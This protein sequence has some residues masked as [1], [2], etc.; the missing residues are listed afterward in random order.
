MSRRPFV[1][2]LPFLL[3]LAAFTASAGS[4]HRF[5]GNAAGAITSTVPSPDGVQLTTITAGHATQLG[6][7]TRSESLLLNPETGEFT[8]QAVFVARNGDQLRA[9]VVGKFVLPTTAAG[10]YTFDGGTGRYRDANGIAGFVVVSEDGVNFD[11]LFRGK[12]VR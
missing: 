10:S 1:F 12:V 8:G 2:A 9:L 4:H 5:E 7:F 6:R 3:L 11:V